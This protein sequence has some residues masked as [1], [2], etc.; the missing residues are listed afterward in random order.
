MAIKRVS[1]RTPLEVNKN[2]VMRAADAC[3]SKKTLLFMGITLSDKFCGAVTDNCI[4]MKA[5]FG[6]ALL[7]ESMSIHFKQIR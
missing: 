4:T 1:S 7:I 5:G 3:G 2:D 6:H